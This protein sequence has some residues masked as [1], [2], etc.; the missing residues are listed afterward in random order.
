MSEAAYDIRPGVPDDLPG[1]V[2][3][4]E[5]SLGSGVAPHTPAFWAWKH[6]DGPFGPSPVSVATSPD[7]GLVGLRVVTNWRWQ[8]EGAVFDAIRPVDT[9][10]DPDWRRRGIFKRLTLR[11]VDEA[12]GRGTHFVFNTPNDASGPGY[13]RMGWSLVDRVGVRVAPVRPLRIAA[14]LRL[15]GPDQVAPLVDDGSLDAL[16]NEPHL[17]AFLAG[18]AEHDA[19]LRTPRDRA[20]IDWRYRRIPGMQY[21]ARWSFDA[22]GG[23]LVLAH[24]RVRRGLDELTVS[25]VLVGPGERSRRIAT[26]LLMDL[27][28]VAPVDHLMAVAPVATRARRALDAAMF[29]PAPVS[30]GIQLMARP[31]SALPSGA[32]DPLHPASWAVSL[33]DLEVF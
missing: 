15:G 30:I 7:G 29:V 5:R 8:S 27:R 24:R 25:E 33:G 23:A 6:H 32:P 1:I 14:R 19:R 21:I 16:L 3:L 2:A 12:D 18:A 9:A 20:F 22:A 31:L 28:R 26:G 10:T 13:Q 4:M 17:D 11:L